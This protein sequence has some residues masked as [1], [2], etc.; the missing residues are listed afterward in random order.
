MEQ[1][2]GLEDVL[3]GER[4]RRISSAAGDLATRFGKQT[5]GNKN[6]TGIS[7]SLPDG[8]KLTVVRETFDDPKKAPEVTISRSVFIG[9]SE[10]EV[11]G[12][13]RT[14]KKEPREERAVVR[15]VFSDGQI[16]RFRKGIDVIDENGCSQPKA[17]SEGPL[18]N[19]D[20]EAI[21]KAIISLSEILET[22]RE[23]HS[24]LRLGSVRRLFSFLR[25]PQPS[26]PLDK[27]RI[28]SL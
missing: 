11:V 20:L 28:K 5:N 27:E 7:R 25:P 21:Q 1:S 14:K 22:E 6:K 18:A 23:T 19:D 4:A 2:V 24:P 10:E 17:K 15:M 9:N 3:Q 26:M 8:S 16:A 12:K 13:D